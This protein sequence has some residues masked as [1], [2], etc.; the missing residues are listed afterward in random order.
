MPTLEDKTIEADTSLSCAIPPQILSL[1]PLQNFDMSILTT[2]DESDHND[3]EETKEKYTLASQE[4]DTSAIHLINNSNTDN[5]ALVPFFRWNQVKNPAGQGSNTETTSTLQESDSDNNESRLE[6]T[7]TNYSN[8][9]H[10]QLFPSKA[11]LKKKKDEKEAVEE[12]SK[13]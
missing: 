1:I 13:E 3:I 8:K 2:H 5:K 6:Q 12:V 10:Y 4:I 7:H 9:N 11:Q